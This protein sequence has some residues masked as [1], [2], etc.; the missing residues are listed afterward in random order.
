M[1]RVIIESHS[2]K[3]LTDWA[4][5]YL[6]DLGYTV[7][8][9]QPLAETPQDLAKRLNLSSRHILR[10]LA[11]PACPEVRV[12]RSRSKR[13]SLIFANAQFEAFLKRKLRN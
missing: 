6:G 1:V 13:I 4:V 5:R 12:V 10:R 8:A 11:H 3:E 7:T 9:T 2:Q